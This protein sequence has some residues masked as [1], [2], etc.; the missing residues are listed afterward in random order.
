MTNVNIYMASSKHVNLTF[1]IIHSYFI[2]EISY[3]NSLFKSYIFY[4]TNFEYL[5]VFIMIKIHTIISY[6]VFLFLI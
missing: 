1:K 2:K 4:E 5:Q 3:L 6:I